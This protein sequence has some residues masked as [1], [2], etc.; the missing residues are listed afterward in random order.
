MENYRQLASAYAH[1]HNTIYA[2]MRVYT[3]TNAVHESMKPTGQYILNVIRERLRASAATLAKLD[4]AD[5][6]RET[7]ETLADH[8]RHLAEQSAE[9]VQGWRDYL[10]RTRGPEL[11]AQLDKERPYH[12]GYP[13]PFDCSRWSSDPTHAYAAVAEWAMKK[14]KRWEPGTPEPDFNDPED[15]WKT[16]A[17]KTKLKPNALFAALKRW[18]DANGHQYTGNPSCL[19]ASETDAP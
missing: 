19:A 9:Q 3:A 18:N 14:W 11:V 1:Q 6:T 2:R 4:A 13:D 15:G 17:K 16:L 5:L 12:D 8:V 10:I 7:R